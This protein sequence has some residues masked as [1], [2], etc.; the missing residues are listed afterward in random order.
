MNYFYLICTLL[1]NTI[2]SNVSGKFLLIET[3]DSSAGKGKNKVNLRGD[4]LGGSNRDYFISGQGSEEPPTKDPT[5]KCLQPI[6]NLKEIRTKLYVYDDIWET[7]QKLGNQGFKKQIEKTLA[8]V[9]K[10]LAR[11]DNG[12]YKLV[13]EGLPTKLSNSD[14]KL[15]DKYQDRLNDNL[16]RPFDKHSIYSLAFT[17]QEAVQNLPNRNDVDVRILILKHSSSFDLNAIAEE[18]CVCKPAGF[19]CIVAWS[20]QDLSDW[21]DDDVKILTHEIGHTLGQ[22]QH[23][24]EFYTKNNKL[25]MWGEVEDDAHIWSPQTREAINSQDHSCLK[26]SDH[27]YNYESGYYDEDEEEY[28]EAYDI[29]E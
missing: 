8:S 29:Q 21:P 28:K 27:S 14:V 26:V 24:E 3:E 15:A 17:F 5:P 6:C 9:N 22:Q 10:D 7:L 16:T 20:I 23:D 19:G 18:F 1:L 25:I 13:V 12:G 11:L 2:I 4:T